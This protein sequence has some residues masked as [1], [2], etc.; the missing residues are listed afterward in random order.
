[1]LASNASQ[2][3]GFQDFFLANGYAGPFPKLNSKAFNDLQTVV[4]INHRTPFWIGRLLLEKA[5]FLKPGPMDDRE[6]H[7]HSD[8]VFK[9]STDDDILDRVSAI[10]GPDLLVWMSQVICRWPG[11]GGA[12]WHID[13]VNAD[14]EG[15]HVSVALSAMNRRNGCLQIIPGTHQYKVDLNKMAQRGECDLADAS[16]MVKLAD[17]IAPENAPHQILSIELEPGEY[18]FTKGGLWHG[19]VANQ[20]LST[21]MA[22]ITRF[23][24][25]EFADRTDH[26]CVL[27]KGQDMY[28]RKSLHSPPIN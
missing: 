3:E 20:T 21:R 13:K 8:L 16:S 5:N 2:A 25:P 11:H 4:K 12:D 24:C 26:P 6:A 1:M 17:R 27:A 7:I 28:Q 18:F 23:M 10:L 14:V 15:V 19:V 22:F 9:A